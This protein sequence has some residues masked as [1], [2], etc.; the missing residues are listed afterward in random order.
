M[1]EMGEEEGDMAETPSM[2]QLQTPLASELDIMPY[3]PP[4]STPKSVKGSTKKE[5]SKRKINMSGYI[6]FSSEMRAVIK[7]QHPDYSFG[8]LSRLVGTEWRNLEATKKAEYEGMISGYP[9]VLP[10]LQGPV[11]GIVSM[12]S[13]QP[14]HP[15]VPPPHQLPP[16][17]PGIP[18]IPP[19]GVIG[20]NVSPMVGTPAPGASPFG[21]QI[22]IL[23][24][25]GQQAPPPYPGQSPA[26][27]PVMQ[28]P[29]TPMFV[30]PPPKTQRLLHSEAYLKYIEGLSAESNSIS[31]W[32]QTLAARRR[33]VHLSKEQ[34]SRLPSHWLKSK[35]A[36]TTMAD[37]LWRLRDLML[38][39]TLNIRQAYNIENV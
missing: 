11:D 5:G 3:T 38:R 25:P 36:H 1:E 37:A 7:A 35:G 21:Q 10:P 20:Q 28:Q 39:D 17:M 13:M 2:P 22:G 4:Q 29:T 16:G 33:D 12:G 18:G 8:E 34:E 30:S 27:Q 6:L 15:G 23:G 26:S 24:P 14:L 19:P 32:D 31:K 9:P